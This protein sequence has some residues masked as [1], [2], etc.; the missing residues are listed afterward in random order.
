MKKEVFF[1]LMAAIRNRLLNVYTDAGMLR[2]L[3]SP[4][5][6]SLELLKQNGESQAILALK[7]IVDEQVDPTQ[8]I[9]HTND[10]RV[11]EH[12]RERLIYTFNEHYD[13]LYTKAQSRDHYFYRYVNK[14]FPDLMVNIIT[15]DLLKSNGIKPITK[16]LEQLERLVSL[17]QSKSI[18]P[19]RQ[20]HLNLADIS[21]CT[22]KLNGRNETYLRSIYTITKTP[23][24]GDY[25]GEKI[26][27]NPRHLQL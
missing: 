15:E 4:F 10:A 17:I 14:T 26:N 12:L 2:T 3:L 27:I 1:N 21:Q 5:F 11:R 18:D 13:L 24:L 22:G 19:I 6:H 9:T 23:Y 16:K 25:V 20:I 7:R 8:K